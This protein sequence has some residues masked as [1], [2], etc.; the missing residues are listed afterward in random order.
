MKRAV[1]LPAVAIILLAIFAGSYLLLLLLA[2]PIGYF[3]INR[4][5]KAAP[6]RVTYANIEEVEAKYG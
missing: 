1:I 2:I 5:E 6:K 4:L 3:F